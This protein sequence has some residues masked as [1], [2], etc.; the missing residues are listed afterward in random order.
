M[1]LTTQL[2]MHVIVYMKRH[3]TF[4]F[5]SLFTTYDHS[6]YSCAMEWAA[7]AGLVADAH[8][9]RRRLRRAAIDAADAASALDAA[10][11]D[12]AVA[13]TD[14]ATA[15]DAAAAA[16]GNVSLSAAA[17]RQREMLRVY[18]SALTPYQAMFLTLDDAD[19]FVDTR[20]DDDDDDDDDGGDGDC[21]I[22][23]SDKTDERHGARARAAHVRVLQAV[24]A[25]TSARAV[26]AAAE[27]AA[28]LRGLPSLSLSSSLSS[29]SSSSPLVIAFLSSD[30]NDHCFGDLVADMFRHFDCTQT[31]VYA[32][33]TAPPKAATA[34]ATSTATKTATA[35]MTATATS[36]K[37]DVDSVRGRIVAALNR[38]PLPPDDN[39]NDNNA[40]DD[41]DDDDVGDGDGS[42]G[43]FFRRIGG[44]DDTAA[45]RLIKSL[46][47]SV[48]IDCNGHTRGHRHTLL[49]LRPARVCVTWLG[50]AGTTAAPYV[51]YVVVD[52][53]LA[54]SPTTA[55]PSTT[56]TTTTTAVA[57]A[58]EPLHVSLPASLFTERIIRMRHCYQVNSHASL[59][60]DTLIHTF[61]D[62]DD[63]AGV[64]DEGGGKSGS[65]TEDSGDG[66]S[67]ARA[68]VNDAVA[69]RRAA[70]REQ[71]GLTDA[72]ANAF[73]FCNFDRCCKWTVAT[74]QRWGRLLFWCRNAVIY[75]TRPPPTTMTTP[76][77]T[78]ATTMTACESAIVRLMFDAAVAAAKATT[79]S[80]TAGTTLADNDAA[81]LT[82]AA[83]A[84]RVVFVGAI[85]PKARFLN[86]LAL[87]DLWL[88]T[89]GYGAHTVSWHRQ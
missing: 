43:H 84:H 69:A 33:C 9:W 29:S 13:A 87:C 74:L 3:F 27:L 12:T 21:N 86:R 14:D 88:D 10:T 79:S 56:L 15:V 30:F 11:A 46:G 82:F 76:A 58:A 38:Q 1:E 4:L 83:F 22:R 8:T 26:R 31:R 17:A 45:A 73:V 5:S 70:L 62:C 77:T 85:A 35:M 75:L 57:A 16:A 36:T 2:V 37:N 42:D 51:D 50:F 54:P 18:A 63:D 89:G 78:M 64:V 72:C 67:D 53:H 25:A 52:E 80:T 20:N 39:D 68:A 59:Y 32:L 23:D 49:A 71:A 19:V 34:T 61:I 81:S 40:D 66:G 7:D 55:T 6:I 24:A 44:V 48:I 28:P 65:G 47:V 60:A 41:D